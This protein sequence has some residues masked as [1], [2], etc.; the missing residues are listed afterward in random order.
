MN[1]LHAKAQQY[2]EEQSCKKIAS[3]IDELDDLLSEKEAEI[4]EEDELD[5]FD[6]TM[7][8]NLR[9]DKH[10]LRYMKG[11]SSVKISRSNTDDFQHES[12][13]KWKIAQIKAK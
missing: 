7:F 6:E 1:W 9:P 10:Q 3:F 13:K 2:Q 4:L 8:A 5:N 12:F 11:S